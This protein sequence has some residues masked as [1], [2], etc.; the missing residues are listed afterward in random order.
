MNGLLVGGVIGEGLKSFVNS[1]NATQDRQ[2]QQAESDETRAMRRRQM[3]GADYDAGR[4]WDDTENKYKPADGTGEINPREQKALSRLIEMQKAAGENWYRTE[5][6]GPRNA[7]KALSGKLYGAGGLIQTPPTGLVN[8][9]LPTATPKPMTKPQATAPVAAAP[10]GRVANYN[11]AEW[12]EGYVPKDAK[13]QMEKIA[14]EERQPLLAQKKEFATSVANKKS[15]ANS[16]VSLLD[17][18]DDPNK[19]EAEKLLAARESIKILNSQQGKDA[20]GA[21]EAARLAGLLEFH[22]LPNITEPGPMFGRAPISAFRGQVFNNYERLKQGI[23]ADEQMMRN[24]NLPVKE[25]KGSAAVVVGNPGIPES[26]WAQVP[27][28]LRGEFV[29]QYREKHGRKKR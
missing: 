29:R 1:Y 12:S 16:M 8:A 23:A 7:M 6:D 17:Q 9:P 25:P 3:A 22:I 27:A 20:V 28:E 2:R 21:E 5:Y 11:P 19:T 18:L 13:K 26:D 4:E 24:P 15:I 10:V 14:E